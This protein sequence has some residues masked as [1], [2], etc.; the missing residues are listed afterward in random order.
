M[1]NI[2]LV[3]VI[4]VVV[5]FI[6][7]GVAVSVFGEGAL[8]TG[9]EKA[10]TKTLNVAVSIDKLSLS[11]MA[12][13]LELQNLIIDNPKGYQHTTLLE[14]GA[15]AVDVEVKSLLGDTVNIEAIKFDNVNLVIEQKMLTNNLKEVLNSIPS[16]DKTQKESTGKELHIDQ[17]ERLSK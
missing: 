2:L 7:V 12:G 8:K 9:I 16:A 1:K 11:L 14:L 3:V 5:L 15:A 10:A 13:K 17:L 6:A 4:V